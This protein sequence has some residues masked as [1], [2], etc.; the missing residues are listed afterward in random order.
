MSVSADKSPVKPTSRMGSQGPFWYY[1]PAPVRERPNECGTGIL[2]VVMP[3]TLEERD[4]RKAINGWTFEPGTPLVQAAQAA[5]TAGF[6]AFE[7]VL[8]A[9]GELSLA[10]GEPECRKLGD[11]I[12]AAGLS[13]AS[14][15]CGLFWQYNFTAPDL[16]N[17]RKA[18]DLAIAGLDRARWLGTD[19]LLIVPGVV[20]HF[21]KPRELLCPYADALKLTFD[22]LRGL[23]P[24]AEKRGV[25]IGIEN[26]WNSFLLSP[27]E[28]RELIDRLNSPWVRVY[29]DVGN[30]V[31][32]GLPEDWIDTLGRRICRI[33][34]KDF[35]TA[36]GTVD[37]FCPL[38]DGDVNWPAVMT[39][40]KRVNYSGP[41]TFEGPGDLADISRRID[42]IL[43][44]A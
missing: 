43:A 25:V 3:R 17:R 1:A 40:L 24:E 29:L 10:T 5:A 41:L 19:A 39:A 6:Q 14:L 27:A 13:I 37:G 33:H 7:P 9:E 28:I 4:L 16:A 32:F 2:P 35:K 18:R 38:G 11:A 20:A 42:T 21:R 31:K 15:A 44:G 26:V 8:T 22:A 30:V 36:V 34:L 23:I 12:R